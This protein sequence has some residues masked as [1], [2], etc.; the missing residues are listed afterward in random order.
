MSN[1]QV[2]II[3]NITKEYP[4]MIKVVV[5]KEPKAFIKSDNAKRRREEVGDNYE[6]QVSSLNR[7]KTL[8]KDL[9]LCNDFELFATFTFNPAKVNSYDLSKC[10]LSMSSWLHN[11]RNKS[12]EKGIEFKYLIIPEQHKSGRWHFHALL[13][14]YTSTL[15]PT[16]AFSPTLRLIYNITSFRSGFTTAVMIDDKQAVSS[17]VTKYITKDFVTLFNQRRFF[18]SRNLIRPVK[19]T[20]STIF[21]TTLPLFRRPVA[22]NHET[23]TFVIDKKDTLIHNGSSISIMSHNIPTTTKSDM[24]KQ[25]YQH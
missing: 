15:K 5:Y 11:Q 23:Q 16:K 9:V 7:T 6:P 14:G 10:W 8:V 4:D 22:E 18:C 12:R 19:R 20:N 3:S 1:L 13:S 21:S 25:Y 2:R 24:Y 17:Y